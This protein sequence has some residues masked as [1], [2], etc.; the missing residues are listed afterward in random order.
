MRLLSASVAATIA[1][2][3]VPFAAWAASEQDSPKPVRAFVPPDQKYIGNAFALREDAGQ[4]GYVVTDGGQSARLHFVDLGA[5][6]KDED[7]GAFEGQIEAIRWLGP[8]RVLVVAHQNAGPKLVGQIF[9]ATGPADG[10]VGP[11]DHIGVAMVA[12]QPVITTF[13]GT[14]GK[15]GIHTVAA[16]AP[17]DLR[18]LTTRTFTVDG[19]RQIDLHGERA[20]LLWWGDDFTIAAVRHPGQYDK[21]RDLQLP[22]RFGRIDLLSGTLFDD[23]ALD[24]AGFARLASIQRLHPGRSTFVH[25][26]SANRKLLLIDGVQMRDL[27]PARPV[28]TYDAATVAS[29]ILGPGEVMVSLTVDPLNPDAVARK[30]RDRPELE[31]YTVNRSSGAMVRRVVLDLGYRPTSW[32]VVSGTVALLRKHRVFARGGVALELYRLPVSP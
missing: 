16:F 30:K 29:Q 18:P 3:T 2:L 9:S 27:A 22:D 31:L 13:T 1:A 14:T 8:G 15:A 6:G 28:H 17:D 23:A 19:R 20:T 12:Q 11:A 32:Q 24:P 7:I 21:A 5:N 10:L 26:D 4:L 25:V